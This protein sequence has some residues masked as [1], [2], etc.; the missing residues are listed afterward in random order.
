MGTRKEKGKR[1]RKDEHQYF[2]LCI[3]VAAV[4]PFQL[5]RS[6]RINKSKN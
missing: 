1:K 5:H 6:R 2:G 3:S 4:E